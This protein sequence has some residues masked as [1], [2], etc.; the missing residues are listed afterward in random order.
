MVTIAPTKPNDEDTDR[1]EKYGVIYL[2]LDNGSVRYRTKNFSPSE[3]FY[4]T[5]M[6]YILGFEYEFPEDRKSVV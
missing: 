5:R 6:D 1:I 2:K 4:M 3:D